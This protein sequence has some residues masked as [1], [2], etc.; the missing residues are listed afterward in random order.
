MI[1]NVTCLLRKPVAEPG[2]EPGYLNASARPC[3]PL[4]QLLYPCLSLLLE[5]SLDYRG[6]KS[7]SMEKNEKFFLKKNHTDKWSY[8]GHQ[9]LSSKKNCNIQVHRPN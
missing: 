9:P 6:E 4:L 7:C 2:V 8:S 1:S 3:I 5:G